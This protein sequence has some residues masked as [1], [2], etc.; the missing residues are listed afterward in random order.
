[1]KKNCL[2]IKIFCFIEIFIF[3]IILYAMPKFIEVHKNFGCSN[4][5]TEIEFMFFNFNKFIFFSVFLLVVLLSMLALSPNVTIGRPLYI[6]SIFILTFNSILIIYLIYA[7]YWP[8]FDCGGGVS[9]VVRLS[10]CVI[11]FI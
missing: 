2:K 3:F 10:K 8:I 9:T 6:S 4:F 1:M 5:P 7:A 11:Q